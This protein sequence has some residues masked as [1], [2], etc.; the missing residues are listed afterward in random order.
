[1]IM[2][3]TKSHNNFFDADNS[4]NLIKWYC[5]NIPLLPTVHPHCPRGQTENRRHC[6]ALMILLYSPAVLQE[7]K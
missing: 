4:P 5:K 7:E 3:R 1:M 6:S 2:C